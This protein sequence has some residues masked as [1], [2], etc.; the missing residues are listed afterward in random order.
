MGLIKK[1]QGLYNL[2][3]NPVLCKGELKI[4]R[5]DRKVVYAAWHMEDENGS[6]LAGVTRNYF[7]DEENASENAAIELILTNIRKYRIGRKKAF[8][9]IEIVN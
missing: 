2:D 1:L 7:V 5:R 9:E 3:K 8:S 6:N 4:L